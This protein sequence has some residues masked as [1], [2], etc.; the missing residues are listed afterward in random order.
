MLLTQANQTYEGLIKENDESIRMFK[1]EL[2]NVKMRC[3]RLTMDNEKLNY[4]LQSKCENF[5][6]VNDTLSN[7]ATENDK[8]KIKFDVNSA[9]LAT[10]IHSNM[11]LN[12]ALFSKYLSNENRNLV[13]LLQRRISQVESL[14]QDLENVKMVSQL[15][16]QVSNERKKSTRQ[17]TKSFLE[18][19]A[20]ST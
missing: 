15:S 5:K 16:I 10:P 13:E 6:T 18:S 2:N 7:L 11:L 17:F 8:L 4:T 20:K 1:D 12:L 19:I 9:V 3:L 14:K